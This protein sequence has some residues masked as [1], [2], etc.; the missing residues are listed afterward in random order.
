[1]KHRPILVASWQ[2]G[3]GDAA[4]TNPIERDYDVRI[5]CYSP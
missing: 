2:S 5:I 3:P 4:L 1:M